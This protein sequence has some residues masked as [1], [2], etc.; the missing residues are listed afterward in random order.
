MKCIIP[1][2]HVKV[3]GR[4]IHSLS[5]IGEELYVEPLEHG[6]TLRTVNSSRSAYACFVFAPDFFQHYDEGSGQINSSDSE[7]T[8]KCKITIKSCMTVFKSLSTIEKTVERC[9]ITMDMKDCKLTFQLHCKHGIVKTHNLAFIECET[10]QAVFSKDTSPNVLKAH[11]RLMADVVGNFQT[12]Q[13]E[14][15]L[16]VN[17]ERI[18][19][20]NYVEDEP[21]P[22]KVM[23]TVLNLDPTEFDLCQ[24]GTDTEVTF[25]L[26]EFRAIL[27]FA[28]ANNLP[29]SVNF[30]TA[31]KPIVFTIP[32]DK[33]YEANFV[34]ATLA[35]L[36]SDSQQ[37]SVSQTKKLSKS[38]SGSGDTI[39]EE[40]S[41]LGKKSSNQSCPPIPEEENGSGDRKS[42]VPPSERFEAAYQE[43]MEDDMDLELTAAVDVTMDTHNATHCRP[44]QI[45]HRGA[46]KPPADFMSQSVESEVKKRGLDQ[47]CED[48]EEDEDLEDT[49]PGT[50][51][52]KKF[53]SLFF[54]MSQ[55][56]TQSSISHKP[57]SVSVLAEDTDEDD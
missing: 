3:F 44:S 56:S 57:A 26:K 27:A 53:K 33:A 49:V 39:T 22:M 24:I 23:H 15:T 38:R 40:P 4:A 48:V 46:V 31:G 37:R 14:V 17:S 1:G 35:D 18:S 12:S 51:P 32:G 25:C 16:I 13:E 41:R 5:K 43:M 20:K 6:L 30:D 10:L 29:M 55:S 28:E 54:G 36:Q 9:K 11:A 34:L 7:D 2:I 19:F 45:Y 42:R 21:D 8:I 50:P 47:T 52:S